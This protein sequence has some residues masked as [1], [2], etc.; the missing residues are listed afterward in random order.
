LKKFAANLA[1]DRAL[2]TL[3][4][5]AE[6]DRALIAEF[7]DDVDGGRKTRKGGRN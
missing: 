2:S 1:I 7:A 4:L 5:D 6:A 3:T